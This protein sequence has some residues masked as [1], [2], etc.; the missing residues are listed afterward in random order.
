LLEECARIVEASTEGILVEPIM[1][2]AV[3]AN[4]A[5]RVVNASPAAR[6]CAITVVPAGRFPTTILA[7]VT[8]RQTLARLGQVEASAAGRL[9]G[10]WTT[11]RIVRSAAR[12]GLTRQPLDLIL[13][14]AA[15]AYQ[16]LARVAPTAHEQ[17]GT[18]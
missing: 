3:G 16:R 8:G 17:Y 9:E 7:G 11:R 6:D 10:F 5:E 14:R 2:L 12:L 1:R 18:E 4:A 15:A 13:G